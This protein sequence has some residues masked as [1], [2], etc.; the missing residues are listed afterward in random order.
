M[1]KGRVVG[2]RAHPLTYAEGLLFPLAYTLSYLTS[3]RT[4]W[5]KWALGQYLILLGLL[6]SQSRGPWIAALVMVLV[7]CLLHRDALFY[8]RLALV[9][10]AIALCFLSPTLRTRAFSITNTA[11]EPNAERLEMWQAGR[12]MV[13]DH[14]LLGVGTGT[15]H[16]VSPQY[17]PHRR[18]T[19][20]PWGHL[21][22]A[23]I[24]VAAERG[25]V[26]LLGF[27]TFIM[28]LA[29]ELWR[30]YR[31]ALK[32]HEE[33]SKIIILTGLLSLV[34]WLV[35]GLTEAVNHDSNVLMMFYFVM[36]IALATARGLGKK[37][38][39]V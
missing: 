3:R 26:G 30:G 25:L 24:N 17:Q 19:D 10:F 5:W 2:T 21:H 34:G 36:G 7:A 11:Y 33:E 31:L 16:L 32:E 22:N 15:M 27:L 39:R 4:D 28:V 6:V 12:R 37:L 14:P 38:K 20:G 35:A 9:Y 8:K 23:Y 1:V 29:C 13:H 18:R